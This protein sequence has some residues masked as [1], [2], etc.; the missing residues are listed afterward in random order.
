[1]TTTI[2]QIAEKAQKNPELVFNSI[3]HLLTPKMLKKSFDI[4]RKDA[5]KG[6]DGVSY[7]D[8]SK[9]LDSNIWQLHHDLKN[10]SYKVQPLKRVWIDKGNNKKRPIGIS[11]IQDKIVQRA[12]TTLLNAIYEQDFYD[13]SYGFRE[14]RN[15]HQALKY[16]WKQ[17]MKKNINWFINADIK[18]CFDNF[19]HQ[20]LRDILRKRVNDGCINWLI[21]IWMKTQII[22]GSQM[23]TNS[24][25]TPQGGII[26]P[27]LANIYL[28]ETIDKWIIEQIKPLL[29]GDIFIVRFADDFIIGLEYQQ[30]AEKLYEVLPKRLE[31]YGLDLSVEKSRLQ[32]FVPQNKE[33]NNTIDFL[34]FTHYWSKTRKGKDTIKKKTRRKSKHR[35]LKALYLLIKTNRHLK[36]VVQFQ[37]IKRKLISYYQYYAVSDNYPFLKML[38]YRTRLF[39]FKMLNRRGGRKKSFTISEFKKFMCKFALPKPRIL[40]VI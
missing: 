22:D 6:I 4:L 27:L 21:D 40:H 31:K 32:N 33:H 37:E 39:W 29:K 1:M 38:Y 12:V 34:G 18:G 11:S 36:V 15:P 10:R 16:F 13:F 20:I 23:S 35:I 2:V 8:Y 28:H 14:K 9:N 30:D 3:A 25:G 19:D 26:S 5:A 17:G 7:A 24:E